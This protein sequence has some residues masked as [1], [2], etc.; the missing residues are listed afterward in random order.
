MKGKVKFF[1]DTP[2]EQNHRFTFNVNNR[3]GAFKCL[4]RYQLKGW[5][6]RAAWYDS[7]SN[8]AVTAKNE[9]LDIANL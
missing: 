5:K 3:Q 7:A 6:I 9:R 2:K 4:K 1:A 8:A